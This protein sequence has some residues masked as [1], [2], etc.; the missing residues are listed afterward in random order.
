MTGVDEGALKNGEK[1]ALRHW[2][3]RHAAGSGAFSDNRLVK[4][5]VLESEDN[6]IL[7]SRN[8]LLAYIVESVVINE[9]TISNGHRQQETSL[10]V[11]QPFMLLCRSPETIGHSIVSTQ[12]TKSE[13]EVEIRDD[14]R[15]ILGVT[16][17]FH[18]TLVEIDVLVKLGYEPISTISS[19]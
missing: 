2:I 13:G 12:S 11:E 4:C 7:T 3:V 9:G 10:V 14:L 15:H 18:P 5:R 19:Q 8:Y 1:R 6:L 17:A 16:V